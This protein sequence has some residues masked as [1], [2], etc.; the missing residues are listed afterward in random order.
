MS[1][2]KGETKY[3]LNSIFWYIITCIYYALQNQICKQTSFLKHLKI[4][5]IFF[6]KAQ[7]NLH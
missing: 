1:V 2:K 7:A 4:E 5:F 3:V 6:E